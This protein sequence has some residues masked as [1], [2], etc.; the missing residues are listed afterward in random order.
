MEEQL[1]KLLEKAKTNRATMNHL[2]EAAISTQGYETVS[3]FREMEKEFYPETPE[4]AAA[5]KMA[6]QMQLLFRLVHLNLD[7][8]T[9]WVVTEAVKKYLKKKGKVDMLDSAT[10]LAKQ[11]E[12][13]G[14]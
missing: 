11:K 5:K 2:I 10:L 4:H 12:I 9:S 7:L 13:F 1:T 3:K 14:E 6:A 8:A